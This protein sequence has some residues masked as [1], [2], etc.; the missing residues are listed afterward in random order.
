MLSELVKNRNEFIQ[1]FG[2]ENC[3]CSG[4]HS[5]Y[6]EWLYPAWLCDHLQYV[7]SAFVHIEI[8]KVNNNKFILLTSPRG[9]LKN[10]DDYLNLHGFSYY[11]KVMYYDTVMFKNLKTFIKVVEK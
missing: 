4:V 11:D 10:I 8:Y 1:E 3:K 7:H 6:P 5:R 2:L 9:F